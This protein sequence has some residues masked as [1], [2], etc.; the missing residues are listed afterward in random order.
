MSVRW[1]RDGRDWALVRVE[2]PVPPFEP[3]RERFL[4]TWRR[5]DRAGIASFYQ[6]DHV[7]RMLASIERSATRRNWDPLPEILEVDEAD[8]EEGEVALT[9]VLADGPLRTTWLFRGDGAW[10]LHRFEFP[11]L[12][13]Q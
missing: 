3:V 1:S 6:K 5:S 10:S 13:D 8:V 2:L 9:L 4:A 7:E 11:P 12:K